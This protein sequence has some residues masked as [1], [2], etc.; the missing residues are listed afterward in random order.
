MRIGSALHRGFEARWNGAEYEAALALAL[1]EGVDL[2]SYTTQT[3]AALLA[4]YY[5]HYGSIERVGRLYPEVEFSYN[6]TKT[7]HADGMPTWTAEGK[8]DGLGWL[9]DGRSVLVEHKSTG[10]SLDADSEYWMRL[11]FDLQVLQYFDAALRGGW[12]ISEVIYDVIRKPSIK[13]RMV[14]DF[15]EYMSKIVLDS[16]G[17]RVKLKNGA[18]KQ[19]ASIVNGETLKQHRET[20]DEFSDRLWRDTKERPE[21]YFA[22]K[23]V[24]VL[25]NDL[26]QFR[27]QRETLVRL[28]ENYRENES[29]VKN[30]EDAWPRSVTKDGC[31][32]CQYK[33][34]CLQNISPDLNALPE[35]FSIGKFNPELQ[36]L[37]NDTEQ[38]NAPDAA[39]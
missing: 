34:F 36:D 30:R 32:F 13:P 21:F 24:P 33:S 15:D 26:R 28:I 7:W 3:V 17:R 22:R 25:E 39:E 4:G 35:G 19:S 37:T 10:D 9:N 20:P 12:N 8:L 16:D 2:D 27:L 23:E 1:P 18:W 29:L 31:K 5:D 6:I 38:E 14:I 11:A